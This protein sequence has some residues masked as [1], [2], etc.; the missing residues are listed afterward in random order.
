MVSRTKKILSVLFILCIVSSMII[1]SRTSGEQPL[2]TNEV[3]KS[4]V[5]WIDGKEYYGDVYEHKLIAESETHMLYLY[6]QTL[7]VIVRDK[8]T[9]AIME[10]TMREDDGKNN[11]K[12]TG[13]MKSGIVLNILDG[14]NDAVQAD[15]LNNQTK[16]DVKI[17]DNGF[18]AKVEF[19][20][21]EIA[22]ELEVLL[23]GSSLVVQIADESII[24]RTNKYRVGA[25]NIYPFLGH[26]Y[27]DNK[28]GYMFIPDGNGALIYLNNK[29]GRLTSGFSQMVYG[30]DI[31][32]KDSEVISLFRNR[33][34][35]VNDSYNIM[36]P[37]FGMVYTDDLLGFIGI[38]E[39]GQERAS[40]EA[41]PNGVHVDYNRIYP[42]FIMRKVY[43]Q[44]TSKSNTGTITQV[45]R[46][47]NHYDIKVRYNFVNNENAN[48]TGLA[49][50]YRDY[51]L[52][53][54]ELEIKD[55]SY[56]SRVDFLGAERE[57]WL[58]FKKKVTMTTL[59][60]V[61]EIYNELSAEEV[62]DILSLYKGWQKGG[63]YNLPVTKY[64]TDN[65]I[66]KEAEIAKYINEISTQGTQ[67]YLYQDALR[68]NPDEKNAT[69][70]VAKM[71]DKRRYEEATYK[72]VYNKFLFLTPN[73]SELL[74][75]NLMPSYKKQG[76][77]N[78]AISGISN[79]L[80]SY[81]YSSNYYTRFDTANY[82]NKAVEEINENFNLVLEQ[83]FA[84]LWKYTDSFID[85]PVGT[86]SYIFADED[87]PFLTIVL[88]GIMPM[89][90]EYVNFEANK[91][92]FKLRLIEQG[93]FPSFYI[94]YEDS[95]NLIYTN[96]SDIYS[97]KYSVYKDEII[98][99]HKEFD[100]INKKTQNAF[101][102][103]H[104]RLNSGVTVVTYDNGVKV[105]INY[106]DKDVLVDDIIVEEMSYKVGGLNG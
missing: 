40:I 7:S 20:D 82:Y 25:V 59:D 16:V 67:L 61:K 43:V 64:K 39:S 31:G 48:Y 51:L 101:I 62:T 84:Y 12:W 57:E 32:F 66:G 104:E 92:E 4:A 44:P 13:F 41:Y 75:K 50:E 45:E 85:M 105:Y 58:V 103:N 17:K 18:L 94:T 24:E 77:D 100:E 86:S 3:N 56:K 11:N 99:Y 70:N 79:N 83:P 81:S 98:A 78:V 30:D 15:L 37:V 65:N 89:Y 36:A 97:T 76:M 87:I 47:R 26:T 42:K 28:E 63:L 49:K 27:L 21:I 34:R 95:S 55:N 9:G 23:E 52:S 5:E 68:I 69:F 90:S 14:V 38:I 93:V 29:E 19:I 6:E 72:Q 106:S 2:V 96:S 46:D 1:W 60:N 54:G 10:S 91:T 35:T 74:L 73:R 22:L 71:I 80:F 8:A 33:F 53:S 88:K 102:V